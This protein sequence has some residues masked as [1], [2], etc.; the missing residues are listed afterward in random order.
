[1]LSLGIIILV[2]LVHA[3]ICLII[4]FSLGYLLKIMKYRKWIF[5]VISIILSIM[6]G[7]K[8]P[9]KPW[10]DRA[11]A[12]FIDVIGIYAGLYLLIGLRNFAARTGLCKICEKFR[13]K[14]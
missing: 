5:L 1:M 13:R 3:S 11:I 10:N 2:C 9:Y 14:K 4:S 12:I 7:F 8:S 6:V